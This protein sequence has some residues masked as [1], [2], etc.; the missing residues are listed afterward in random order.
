MDV[1]GRGG[2]WRKH[3]IE[4]V[5]AWSIEAKF[6]K[7]CFEPLRAAS[8]K[9]RCSKH[10]RIT[11]EELAWLGGRVDALREAVA[12]VCAERIEELRRAAG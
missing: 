11:P 5:V 6:E 3:Q 2:A 7:R 1:H 10:Y 8:I 12:V 9:A 4:L